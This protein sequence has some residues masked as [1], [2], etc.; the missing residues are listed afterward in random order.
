M[1]SKWSDDFG[2]DFAAQY[3]DV[4]AWRHAVDDRWSVLSNGGP[5][6]ADVIRGVAFQLAQALSDVVDLVVE[7]E[8]VA[9]VIEGAVDVVDYEVV[10][11]G[12][13][14][15]AVR[16][17]K[18]RREP[19]TWSA[20]E[21]A[22]ILCALGEV[23]DAAEAEFAFL[24]DAQLNDSGRRLDELINAMRAD[25]DEHVLRRGAEALGRGGVQLPPLDVVRRV[26]I[27]T[28]MGTA[29][30]ILGQAAMRVLTLMQRA[31]LATLE[32]AENAVNGLFRQLFVIGGHVDLKRRTVSRPRCLP[33]LASVRRAC[34]AGRPGRRK[35][36]PPTALLYRK[37]VVG[38]RDSSHWT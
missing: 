28:R 4:V 31:R 34:G 38:H 8:G 1:A 22:R 2:S 33:R 14:R 17:A 13:R 10:D 7:G 32:D 21:L 36:S 30:S 35:P 25:P 9:V 26:R 6:G 29:E 18:T 12:G 24:T 19:G 3:R 11:H 5:G 16:Q 27:L 23:D 20:S 37:T 15:I